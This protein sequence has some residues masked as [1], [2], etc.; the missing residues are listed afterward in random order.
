[1]TITGEERI[2]RPDAPAPTDDVSA[3][4]AGAAAL[5]AVLLGVLAAATLRHGGFYPADAFGVVIVA[6]P[7]TVAGLAWNRDRRGLVVGVAFSALAGWWLVRAVMERRPAAFLPLGASI[8]AFVAALLVVRCLVL[9]DRARV[10][11]AVVAVAAAVGATGLV[12][13]LGRWSVLA[14]PAGRTWSASSTL[15]DP[16]AVAVVCSV[17]LL[18][19]MALDL[20]SPLGRMAVCLCL[21]GA[22][23]ARSHWDLVAL[24]CGALLIPPDRWRQ[25]ARPLL[26]GSVAGLVVVGTSVGHAAG[27]GAWLLT[28]VAVAASA[29]PRRPSDPRVGRRVQASLG[30]AALIGLAVAVLILPTGGPQPSTGQSQTLAW[31]ASGDAW[32]S[33][34]VIGVGPPRTSTVRGPVAVYP[35]L[36]PDSYL[37]VAADGG[38]VGMLLLLTGG[39]AVVAAARRRD[40]LG[41]GAAA[42]TVAFAVSGFVD[43]SWQFPAVALLGGC[44]AGLALTPPGPSGPEPG[45]GGGAGPRGGGQPERRSRR[46]AALWAVAVL[47]VV[48]VQVGVG[49]GARAGGAARA[50]DAEPPHT[51]H[52]DRPGRTI[53]TGADPTDPYMVKTGGRYLLY[54]SEGTS[55]LNVPLWIG[56]RPGRWQKLVDALPTLPAWAHGGST[57]APDVQQVTGGWALY[58]TTLV[59]G[60]T[61]ETRCIGAAFSSSPLGPFVATDRPFICQL[62]HRGSIDARVIVEPGNRLVMLWKS[63]DNA[64]PSTPGPDQDGLTGIYAQGLS[65]D[66]RTLLGRPVKILSPGEPWE[67]TIVEAPDMIQAWGTYWLFFSGNW[68]D[69]PDYGIGVAACQSPF[70]PCTDTDPVP[71]LGSNLQGAGPGEASLYEEGGAVW[72]L[73]NPFKGSD[74]GPVVPRPV[75]ITRL[76]FTPQGPYLAAP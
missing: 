35:G 5:A 74:P 10:A 24:A 15:T 12:G 16:G 13:V 44:A 7:L 70:G 67:G 11:V 66:G 55:F 31:S 58:F 46:A 18:L 76:G 60:V 61:P 71:F 40:L 29:A 56:S 6:V 75:D 27:A 47:A 41:S 36:V 30:A 2:S 50:S 33:A 9:R 69:Q 37:T 14:Q 4:P 49:A 28:A 52:S 62:D 68:F 48:A 3:S 23:A 73:Y 34:P 72:L 39:A 57:W 42:A 8:L 59:Q 32:R 53:L 21:A 43:A 26:A 1:M 64:D 25:A 45:P 54:T 17:G 20:R 19:A 22:L 51:T 38:A 65:A 63:D